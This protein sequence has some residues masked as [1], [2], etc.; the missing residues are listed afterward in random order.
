MG[1]LTAFILVS[2]SLYAVPQA[3]AQGTGNDGKDFFSG[4]VEMLASKFHLDKNEV[5]TA[6][7]DYHTQHKQKMLETMQKRQED[8]LTQ[9]VKDGKITDAQKQAILTE[10]K[11]LKDKY[12]PDKLKDLT[13]DQ[14]RQQMQNM[15]QELDAWVKAQG[16][17]PSYI[18]LH[19]GM[20]GMRGI[21]RGLGEKYGSPSAT[22]TP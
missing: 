10:L 3:H 18:M 14:R 19:F 7:T 2:S 13:P 16:I 9:L 20:G 15:K 5:K 21:H 12:G 17:D 11:T 22:P 6:I 4:L 1:P 8:R